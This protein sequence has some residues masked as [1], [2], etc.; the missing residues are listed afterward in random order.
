MGGQQPIV[1]ATIQLYAAGSTGYGSAY[2]YSSGSSL[3]GTHVVHTMAGGSF[4]LA[5]TITCPSNSTLVYLVATGGNPGSFSTNPN[6]ALMA[7][8]GACGGINSN[9]HIVVNELTTVASVWA[10]SPFMTGIT[11]IGTSAGNGTGLTNAFATVNSLANIATGGAGGS[12]LP[13][14][15]TLPVNK[16]NSLADILAACVNSAG[17]SAGDNN[18]CGT[19]FTNTTVGASVPTDTLTAAMNMAQHPNAHVPE[20]AGLATTSGPFQPTMSGTPTDLRLVLTYTGGG[21]SSPKGLAADSSGNVWTANSGNDSVTELANNGA[22]MSGTTG[23]RVGSLSAPTSIAIDLSGN[24]WVA[25]SGNGSVTKVSAG[26]GTGTPFTGGGLSAP[27]SIAV[28]GA[29]IV[30]VS[31]SGSAGVTQISGTTLTHYTGAGISAPVSIAV[32]AK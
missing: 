14:G 30:W 26:G 3:L 4:S 20:L 13:P 31:N 18:A 7:A 29:G 21:L 5:G 9:T 24:A 22:P 2:P 6:I 1:G 32:S 10:L 28:D 27:Q 11:N 17:G 16:I 15:A 25:N 23:Y 19:L 8:L 12:S